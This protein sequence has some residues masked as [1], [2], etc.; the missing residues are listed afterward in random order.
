MIKKIIYT[1]VFIMSFWVFSINNTN[2]QTEIFENISKDTV[3]TEG[4]SPYIINVG[5]TDFSVD[6]DATLTIE[7]GVVVKFTNGR[8]L[9]VNGKLIAKGT[10]DKN[11][12]FTSFYDM[13]EISYEQPTKGDWYGVIINGEG[14]VLEY[15]QIKYAGKKGYKKTADAALVLI[16]KDHFIHNNFITKSDTACMY[17]FMA[18]ASVRN[19]VFQR[20]DGDGLITNQGKSDISHNV[21]QFNQENGVTLN[22]YANLRGNIIQLNNGDGITVLNNTSEIKNNHID[23]NNKA[24]IHLRSDIPA[25]KNNAITSNN[26]GIL[27]DSIVGEIEIEGNDIIGNEVGIDIKNVK[28]NND[29][30]NL[31]KA[32]DNFWGDRYGPLDPSDD[33][34]KGGLYNLNE[35]GDPVSDFVDYRPWSNKPNTKFLVNQDISTVTPREPKIGFAKFLQDKILV[36]WDTDEEVVLFNVYKSIYKNEGY[37][38]IATVNVYFFE[39]IE[40][41]RGKTYYYKISAVDFTG[42]ESILSLPLEVK[43]DLIGTLFRDIKNTDW[44]SY[45]VY[46]LLGKGII[47]GYED[48]TFRPNNFITRAELIK[49]ALETNNIG[50]VYKSI[51]VFN[52]IKPTDWFYGYINKAY[53]EGIIEKKYSKFLPNNFITRAEALKVLLEANGFTQH[54]SKENHFRDVN[55]NDW[56]YEY[57]EY[58]LSR[59]I[60]NNKQLFY[61]SDYIT[62]AEVAK[63]VTM[64]NNLGL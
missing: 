39:D 21:I 49:I 13:S 56:Y 9:D 48:Q 38:K 60:I 11:I 23:L 28:A 20:C 17:M 6:E 41:E 44:F 32:E 47:K 54:N 19:N 22:S 57:T 46:D 12:I 52:D 16:G 51:S 24:G 45:Y 4:K 37:K 10:P 64:I 25:I 31:I 34:T 5:S 42:N 40:F 33:V 7:P 3:W 14:S 59:G 8:A 30:Y 53:D 63:I 15:T 2:A 27:I 29:L 1:G 35:A 43:T 50:P 58:A 36:S 26:T 62:R 61:P 55:K 18:Y